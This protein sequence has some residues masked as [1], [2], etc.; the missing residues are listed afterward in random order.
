MR[1]VV[2]AVGLTIAVMAGEACR[3]AGDQ[4]GGATGAGQAGGTG[5]AGRQ[6]IPRG[7]GIVA[8]I[9]TDPRTF[10]RYLH[11][12][13]SSELVATL[14]HAKLVRLNR[15][16]QDL[17]LWLAE[18]S[19]RSADGLRYTLKLRPNVTFSDGHPFTSDDVLFSFEAAYDERE[20]VLLG[21][22]LMV[23][24]KPLHAAAPDP[25]T[26]VVTFPEPFAPGVRI[27]DNLPILPRHKLGAALKAGT[28]AKMW[29]LATPPGELAGLGPFVLTAYAPG[30]R[31]TFARNPRYWRKDADG[32][33]L[34]YLDQ[35]T[36][37]IVPEQDAELLRLEAG[38]LDMT[39]TEMR[40]ED[41]TPL[42]RAADAGRVR[43]LE[44]GVGYAADSL[45]FNLKPGGL[46]PKDR[47][48]AWL[49]HDALRRAISMAVDRQLFAN[50]VFLGAGVPVYGPITPANRKWVASLPPVPHDPAGAVRELAA[51][52]LSDRNGDGLLEDAA[53]Q[54][55]RFSL[56][57]QKGNTSIERGAAVIRDELKKIGVTVDVVLLEGN[58]VIQHIM[59]GQYDA[60]YF[61]INATDTDP[62]I[63]PDFWLS[64]GSAH[65]WN[66]EQKTPATEWERRIDDLMRRQM[67]SPDEAERKRLF[68][69]VQTIFAEHLPMIQFVAPRIYVAAS[70]RVA[71]LTPTAFMRPQLLWSPDTIAVQQ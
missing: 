5:G 39:T 59:S 51:I 67:A 48:A 71:N 47:R 7:G 32:E 41:Y 24:G 42:K 12:D 6:S 14:T 70:A 40:P 11:Q 4:A 22:A 46:G 68:D 57:A 9:H 44:L 16:T 21:S 66:L 28:F 36:V 53:N 58:A 49:Q 18:S 29:G 26:V 64:S 65:A 23:G 13:A 35:V 27:L 19:T 43:V 62:A 8:S 55:A 10:N 38:Q 33:A 30:Q 37:E 17:E 61:R 34:P 15:V 1:S 50:T 20:G 56:L 25:S 45:W 54:S 69:Q 31:L 2:V 3:P 63:N 52:G 60:V